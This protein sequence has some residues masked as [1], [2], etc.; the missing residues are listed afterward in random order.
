MTEYDDMRVG[1]EASSD[2]AAQ[3]GVVDDPELQAYVSG[4]G[5]KLLRGIPVRFDYQFAVVD[6][7]EPNA[8]ALPGGYIFISRGLLALTNSEDELACVLGHEIT[9]A[10]HRHAAA[11]QQLGKRVSPV[12]MPWNRA[13]RMAAYGRDMERDA[14]KGGQILCAAAG[15]D[16]MGMSTFLD[17]L[18]QAERL[19]MGYSR[20]AS[21]FATHPGSRE[22]AAVNAVRAGEM[23]WRRD[24]ALADSRATLMQQIDG[25]ALGQRPEAGVFRGNNFLHP[26]LDFYVRF[27]AGWIQSNSNRAVGAM[28]VSKQAVSKL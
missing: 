13:A 7:V 8:F 12:A 9:H 2:V 3:I 21:F 19:E 26:D 23:R 10:A 17:S 15:Y 22:R 1:R 14:D 28:Q 11:Q 25:L 5:R 27:P 16:P 6:Q 4:I 20:R 18:G 24:P